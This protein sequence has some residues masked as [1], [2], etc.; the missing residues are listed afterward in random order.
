MSARRHQK[1]DIGALTV[2]CERF[3][4]AHKFGQTIKVWPGAIGAGEPREVKIC[5]PGAYVLGGHTAVVQV[6][7]GHGC[8]ALDHVQTAP[9]TCRSCGCTDDDCRVCV[10]RTGHPCRWVEVDLCSACVEV[11]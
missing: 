3:N 10:E 9:R 6:T 1:P 11:K 2:A 4:D 5:M 7:G 8:I